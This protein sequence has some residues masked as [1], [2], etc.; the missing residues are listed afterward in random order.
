MN[1]QIKTFFILIGIFLFTIVLTTTYYIYELHS[2]Y[3]KKEDLERNQYL[4]IKIADELRQSSDDLS[5]FANKYVITSNIEYK[6][7]YFKVLDIR[8]GKIKKPENYDG[9]YWNLLD[10]LRTQ[11]HP[12]TKKISLKESI[13]KLPYNKY[14]LQKIKKAHKNSDDLVNIELEAF[15]AVN[16]LFKSNEPAIKKGFGR[17]FAIKLMNS[18]NYY[19]AKE[20]IMLPIDEL[21][22]SL[23]SRTEHSLIIYNNTIDNL[24]TIIY[25]LLGLGLI[26]FLTIFYLVS[27]KILTPINALTQAIY[28]FEKG[29]NSIKNIAHYNDE[30]GLMSKQFFKMKQ[31]LDNDY[32]DIKYLALTDSLT[33]IGNRRSFFEIFEKYIKLFHRTDEKMSLMILDI[34]HFKNV[35]DTYGHLVGDEVLKF[36]T[37]C[38]KQK[39][40]DSDIFARFGG[41]EFII[42]LPKTNI[43]GCLNVANNIRA[44]IESYPC[45][46]GKLSVYITV[47]IGITEYNKDIETKNIIKRADEALYTAKRDGRN[48]V[49]IN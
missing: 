3:N 17:H 48:R 27:K 40:R 47:S 43:D 5:K 29:D 21:L 23:K 1:I 49:E 34:D 15:N 14:E 4:M 35:N 13:N 22:T 32:K 20:K 26:M 41:E 8:N 39:I 30:V 25:I 36:L 10:P 6:N 9:T 18:K 16:G 38:I 45:I 24:F 2:V 37:H 44:H 33:G 7:N 42:L 31:R 28:S 46:T 12:L 19:K 11:K